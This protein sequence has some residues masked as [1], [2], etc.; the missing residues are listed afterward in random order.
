MTTMDNLD[1]EREPSPEPQ[2]SDAVE[3]SDSSSVVMK[4]VKTLPENQQ[5]VVRLKFQNGLSYK[6]IAEIT[7]LSVGNVGFIL[8]TALSSIRQN[9][10]KQT[11]LLSATKGASS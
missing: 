1:M 7:N 6:E 3:T 5:D 4:I 2:P 11:D 9:L 8:H 10:R